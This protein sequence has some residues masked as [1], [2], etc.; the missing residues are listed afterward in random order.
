MG[1]IVGVEPASALGL[2]VG[3]PASG[4]ILDSTTSGRPRS[5][6]STTTSGLPRLRRSRQRQLFPLLTL[7]REGQARDPVQINLK[8]IMVGG[9]KGH[10]YAACDDCMRLQVL[11]MYRRMWALAL[12]GCR[13]RVRRLRH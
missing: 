3:S 5:S 1:P 12:L 7:Y 10:Q 8:M 2:S 9:R 11:R 6:G 13:V 4:P